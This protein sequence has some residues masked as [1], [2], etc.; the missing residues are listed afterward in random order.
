MDS[1]EHALKTNFGHDSFRAGQRHV[2]ESVIAGQD[3]FVLMPTGGG[4][5]L[6]YQLP[7]LLLPGLTIVISPLIALMHDQVDRLR[8]N[9]IA[10]TF[11]NSSLTPGE[12]RERERMVLNGQTQ[13]LYVAPE[14]LVTGNFLSMLDQV[15]ERVGISLVAVDEAHCVS[16]WGHD[17]RPEYRQIGILRR[18]FPRVPMMALTATATERVRRDILSQ[19]GLRDPLVHIASFNRPNLSYE[20]RDKRKGSFDELVRLLR[21]LDGAS[22]IVYCQSRKSVEEISTALNQRGIESLPYHAGIAAEERTENQNRF[23]RDD[24]PVLVATIAFGMGIGKPDIRA[25][26]HYDLPRNLEGYYQESG[27]AGRDGLPARCT[28]FYSRGDLAK[29]GYLIDQKIDE[30]EQRIAR[31]QLQQ[32]VAY[33]ESSV[34]RRK[35]LLAYFGETLEDEQCG[36]CDTCARPTVLEDRTKEAIKLLF[37]IGKTEQRYGMRHVIDV[38]R[39]A[40]TQKVR[41]SGHDQL[42]IYG[43]GKE[44]SADEWLRIGRALIQ[45]GLLDETHDGYPIPRLNALSLEVIRKQRTVEIA[46]PVIPV[47]PRLERSGRYSASGRDSDE[48]AVPDAPG[49]EELFQH[50]RKLRKQLAD[51]QGVPPYVIF[52]DTSL[53]AMARQRPQTERQFEQIPGVGERKLGAFYRIFTSEI[54]AFCE[55]H[56]LEMELVRVKPPKAKT[57]EKPAKES[58]DSVP[59]GSVTRQLTLAMFRQGLQIDE[60]AQNRNLSRGTILTHLAE[61]LESGEALDMERLIR[62]ER[63]EVIANALKEVGGELLKP[64]K[65]LLGDEYSYDEIRLVRAAEKR[66]E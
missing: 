42:P 17:F 38:L 54:C 28:I 61:L 58:S 32:V 25:V 41:D 21:E 62:P 12:M 40:Q 13:L 36:N 50:L 27:R 44:L 33:C 29:V 66:A 30:Q 39:G 64:V 43:Y 10:A 1:I 11:I 22:V 6:T 59:A 2:I 7:A 19:L 35:V 47:A 48:P 15:E 60:I 4:K 31:Q 37:C 34:C 65:E 16:E 57:V 23:I 9:G 52:P 63:Y 53:Q 20:V 26:I 3:A 49:T 45:Q 51:E 5:S 56:G 46:A 8:A 18:R 24:V 14:R 55:E